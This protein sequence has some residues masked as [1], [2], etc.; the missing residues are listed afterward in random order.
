MNPL[1][2][3]FSRSLFAAVL[4]ALAVPAAAQQSVKIAYIDPLSGAFANV[5]EQG[6]KQFQFVI[7]DINKRSLAGAG[8]KLEIVPFDNKVSPQ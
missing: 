5:G 6:L 7:E 4:M 8:V 1:N 3:R 2:M